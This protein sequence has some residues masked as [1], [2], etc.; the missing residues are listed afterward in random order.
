MPIKGS[1]MP[2]KGSTEKAITVNVINIKNTS[3]LQYGINYDRFFKLE[4]LM[5]T[6]VTFVTKDYK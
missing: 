2:I 6:Y 4:A 5:T 3:L 1:I